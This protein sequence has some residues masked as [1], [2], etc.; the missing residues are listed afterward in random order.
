MDSERV[1]DMRGRTSS[2]RWSAVL[3]SKDAQ[4]LARFYLDLLGWRVRSEE[5]NWVT[6]EPGDGSGYLAFQTNE[7]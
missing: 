7:A 6:I 4:V 3:D 2:T 1:T 5:P